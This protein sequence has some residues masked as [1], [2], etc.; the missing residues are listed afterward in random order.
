[1]LA[2]SFP[3][4][5]LVCPDASILSILQSPL[6]NRLS[7][8]ASN[9]QPQHCSAVWLLHYTKGI[10]TNIPRGECASQLSAW[11]QTGDLVLEP[12]PPCVLWLLHLGKAADSE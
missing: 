8:L 2:S 7:T 6:P 5:C 1:M 9:S 4:D 3:S 12:R 10:V 11:D